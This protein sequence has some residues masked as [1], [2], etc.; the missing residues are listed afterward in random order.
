MQVKTSKSDPIQIN[1][2]ELGLGWGRIGMTLCPGKSQMD[3]ISGVWERDLKTDLDDIRK[4]GAKHVFSLITQDEESDLQV[5]DLAEK[6]QA[7]G[8]TA[9][10]S[11]TTDGGVPGNAHGRP[12]LFNAE[13]LIRNL[14]QG[15]NILVHC[16]GGLGR[17]GA[18]VAGLLV[19]NGIDPDEAIS[20]VRQV[21]KGAI[22]TTQQEQWVRDLGTVKH[23]EEMKEFSEGFGAEYTARMKLVFAQRDRYVSSFF[24]NWTGDLLKG[25]PAEI[26]VWSA[27]A[28]PSTLDRFRGCLLGGAIG[29]ALGAAV[30]FMGIAEIRQKFG[31]NGITEYSPIYGRAGAITDD[32]Q[33]TLF[34]AEGCIRSF[35]TFKRRGLSSPIRVINNSYKRWLI[36][37]GGNPDFGRIY[38]KTGTTGWLL[39]V[40]DLHSPRAPGMTCIGALESGNS[41]EDSKGCG[42]VMRVAPIGLFGATGKFNGSVYEL[43]CDS[44]AIT[45]GHPTGY[46]SSGILAVIV[47]ELATGSTII[48]AC[49]TA[50]EC[51]SDNVNAGE[52]RSSVVLA[53]DLAKQSVPAD[54]AISKLGAGWIAEE[55]LAI[56]IYSALVAE[57]FSHGIRTAVNHSGDSDSTGSITGQILGASLGVQAID[58]EWLNGLEL[59]DVIDVIAHDL[60][61]I[62]ND[63]VGASPPKSFFNKYPS[64]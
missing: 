31:P 59:R 25:A 10:R 21:R 63:G 20:Q 58:P 61:S 3:G 4:W 32:T 47:Y 34:T 55:A 7:L 36:T 16:K 23:Q 51:V 2:I 17:S 9:Y 24:D 1:W 52:A 8:M 49:M 50:L 40:K 56:G 12:W 38:E 64:N 62:T 45:H 42:G 27:D 54:E 14:S 18:F 60:Y 30:E 5:L 35:T 33:M 15:E 46:I 6:I 37:Q 43:G 19:E 13:N 22:E 48:D 44:A 53:M 57:S 29:D 11:D 39:D 28:T 41:V 26:G